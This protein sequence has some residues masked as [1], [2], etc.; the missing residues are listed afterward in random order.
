MENEFGKIHILKQE[1]A[2]VNKPTE[3]LLAATEEY[4]SEFDE[5]FVEQVGKEIGFVS[6]DDKV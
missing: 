3:K 1:K 2:I 5:R 6:A 4:Q